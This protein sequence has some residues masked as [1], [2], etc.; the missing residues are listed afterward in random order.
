VRTFAAGNIKANALIKNIFCTIPDT[1]KVNIVNHITPA[2]K[3]VKP[4][5]ICIGDTLRLEA[6]LND[7]N[8]NYSNVVWNFNMGKGAVKFRPCVIAE[9]YKALYSD[10]CGTVADSVFVNP[11]SINA[12][13]TMDYDLATDSVTLTDKSLGLNIVKY[14]WQID[15]KWKG[16][17]PILKIAS[18][19]KE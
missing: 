17:N 1:F 16:E 14:Q 13:F 9:W 6:R 3:I 7:T 5:P 4:S 18:P 15:Q 19:N 8:A 2:I 11:V 12:Q 10:T